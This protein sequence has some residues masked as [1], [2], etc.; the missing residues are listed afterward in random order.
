MVYLY[1]CI[2]FRY[3][4][5]FIATRGKNWSEISFNDII[6]TETADI[7]LYTATEYL[8]FDLR[9]GDEQICTL[10]LSGLAASEEDQR[11]TS[12]Q[13]IKV[14]HHKHDVYTTTRPRGLIQPLL[15]RLHSNAIR[16]LSLFACRVDCGLTSV[17][18]DAP[19]V[20]TNSRRRRRVTVVYNIVVIIITILHCCCHYCHR[21]KWNVGRSDIPAWP[22][23]GRKFRTRKKS[24]SARNTSVPRSAVLPWHVIITVTSFSVIITMVLVAKRIPRRG[25]YVVPVTLSSEPGPGHT[26]RSFKGE[27]WSGSFPRILLYIN[28]I[29]LV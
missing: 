12:T 5:R 8:I 23:S 25:S 4:V 27:I 10:G 14:H 20:F 29:W 22:S 11:K 9:I 1:I 26:R 13:L 2:V 19:C 24:P 16:T 3:S 15:F 6:Y 21:R 28:Y 7:V 18:A 17:V